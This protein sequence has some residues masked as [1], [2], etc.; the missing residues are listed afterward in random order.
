M[1]NLFVLEYVVLNKLMIMR[2]HTKEKPNQCKICVKTFSG[3]N[4]LE[5]HLWKHSGEKTY[6]CSPCDS[7]FSSKLSVFKK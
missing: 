7:F 4:N 2:T 5:C 3:D 6:Q 1:F